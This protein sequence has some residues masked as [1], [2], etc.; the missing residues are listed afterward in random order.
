MT[1]EE[2]LAALDRDLDAMF[3]SPHAR[4]PSRWSSATIEALRQADIASASTGSRSR[5]WVRAAVTEW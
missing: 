2:K 3:G 1:V 5:R 4:R